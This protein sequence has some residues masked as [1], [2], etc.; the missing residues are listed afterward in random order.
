MVGENFPGLGEARASC[1]ILEGDVQLKNE[2]AN[3]GSL[4]F[5]GRER[6]GDRET[7]QYNI[8]RYMKQISSECILDA[9]IT[10]VYF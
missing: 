2:R 3:S 4:L 8:R 7:Q 9:E 5:E 6:Q 10:S 1:W